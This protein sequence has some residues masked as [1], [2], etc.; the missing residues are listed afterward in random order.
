MKST[1]TVPRYAWQTF[2]KFKC[3][4]PLRGENGPQSGASPNKIIE[5]SK[6]KSKKVKNQ[7]KLFFLL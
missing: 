7:A 3:V 4:A 5:F 2:I 1:E 6:E